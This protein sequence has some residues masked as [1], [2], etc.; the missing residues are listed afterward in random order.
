VLN[1]STS[2]S[3]L[4]LVLLSLAIYYG[5]ATVRKGKTP[6]LR[7]IA[8]LNAIEEAVGRATEMGKPVHYTPGLAAVDSENAP[9]TL[10]ALDILG[11]VATLC[12]NLDCELIV[13]NINPVTHSISTE[14]VR[15]AFRAAG[16]E[17]RFKPDTVRFLSSAQFA[18]ASQAMGIMHREHIAANMMI[19]RFGS[20]ALHLAEAASQIGAIQVA[21][22]TNMY[23]LCFFVATCDYTLLGDEMFAGGAYVSREPHRIG[24]IIGQDLGK[25]A[26]IGLI[27]IGAVL[28]TFGQKFLTDFLSKY[29][30]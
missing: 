12:A 29:G 10:A 26:C 23:Q 15:Q 16:A 22:T 19:G 17:D 1:P 6:Y 8:G 5:T 27:V 4:W 18:Y 30:Q 9:E 21:G 3:F 14:I 20:E 13:T 7:P 11:Y 25:K 2:L 24:S 28:A